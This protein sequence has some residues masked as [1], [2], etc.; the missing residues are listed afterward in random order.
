MRGASSPSSRWRFSPPLT[1]PSQKS[2]L[3]RCA[4]GWISRY[5]LARFRFPCAFLDT[6]RILSFLPFGL[7]WCAK[8][9]TCRILKLGTPG[10]LPLL[11]WSLDFPYQR[12]DLQA[13]Q[14]DDR[15]RGQGE[16]RELQQ[17][18]AW[19]GMR[20]LVISS[21]DPTS[22]PS[23]QHGFMRSLFIGR[24]RYCAFFSEMNRAIE[25][26]LGDFDVW[27]CENR[28]PIKNEIRLHMLLSE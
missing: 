11:R 19:W 20:L 9:L 24:L 22:L 28:Y 12:R 23:L 16:N 10:Y 18:A 26:A 3:T 13:G 6:P 2:S 15:L 4:L 21:V 14:P 25:L 27:I 8:K 7:D 17:Q 1:V 5:A